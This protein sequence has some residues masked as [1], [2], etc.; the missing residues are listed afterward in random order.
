MERP[1]RNHYLT[2][3]AMTSTAFP[4]I[5]DASPFVIAS[6]AAPVIARRVAPRQS[7][8]QPGLLRYARNDG[9]VLA[10]FGGMV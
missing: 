5:A 3:T 6:I 4:I 10:R 2:I 8:K 9:A 1:V 7:R